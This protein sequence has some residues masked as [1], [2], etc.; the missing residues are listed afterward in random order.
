[1]M[2]QNITQKRD[3]SQFL[4]RDKYPKSTECTFLPRQS[5]TLDAKATQI[6]KPGIRIISFHYA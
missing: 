4:I 3:E 1:M 2:I 5:E 6:N